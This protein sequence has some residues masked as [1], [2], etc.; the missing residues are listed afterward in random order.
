MSLTSGKSWT[1]VVMGDQI[2]TVK[3]AAV[4]AA[5][6]W[7]DREAT[8]EKACALIDEAGRNGAEVIG[9]SPAELDGFRRAEIA[10]W[11]KLAKDNKIQMD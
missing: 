6:V 4:Q 7:L 3:L 5:P 11:T 9:S 1:E 8:V 2:P 10:K